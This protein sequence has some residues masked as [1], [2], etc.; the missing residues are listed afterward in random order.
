MGSR[1]KVALTN[2]TNN[3]DFFWHQ[4]RG[5]ILACEAWKLKVL[6]TAWSF[7]CAFCR[8]SAFGRYSSR[9]WAVSTASCWNRSLIVIAK[10]RRRTELDDNTE[11]FFNTEQPLSSVRKRTKNNLEHPTAL[12]RHSMN[13]R[14]LLKKEHRPRRIH[15]EQ[16][17]FQVFLN[18][19]QPKYH[20][21]LSS[22]NE[23]KNHLAR[24]FKKK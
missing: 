8:F 18:S 3:G 7:K 23:A 24:I 4:V 16:Q 11:L 6:S 17:K 21:F 5:E 9:F 14:N 15:R 1:F 13:Y 22:K 2:A 20:Y 12:A 10:P 19:E